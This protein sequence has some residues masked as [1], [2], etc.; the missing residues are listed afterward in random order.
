MKINHEVVS[1]PKRDM[2][3][4]RVEA[5]GRSLD[6]VIAGSEITDEVLAVSIC[7]NDPAASKVWLTDSQCHLSHDGA[8][9][10]VNNPSD[11]S[12]RSLRQK[13]VLGQNEKYKN[14]DAGEKPLR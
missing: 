14:N 8:G 5:S 2:L 7:P 12:V 9:S 13:I 10:I 6:L 3:H 11:S 1:H 4:F